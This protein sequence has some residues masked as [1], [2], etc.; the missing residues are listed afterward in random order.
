MDEGGSGKNRAGSQ[1]HWVTPA[2]TLLL[3]VGVIAA[4]AAAY[5]TRQQWWDMYMRL[6]H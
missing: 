1:G 6:I 2:V 4:G 3:L 5:Y